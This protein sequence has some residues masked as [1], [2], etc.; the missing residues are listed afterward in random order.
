MSK[1][2][3]SEEAWTDASHLLVKAAAIACTLQHIEDRTTR[4][5]VA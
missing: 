3:I 4:S 1:H 2:V 5:N